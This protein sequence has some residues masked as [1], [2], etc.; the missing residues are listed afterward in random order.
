[1]A[2]YLIKGVANRQL[3]ACVPGM[4]AGLSRAGL[5]AGYRDE[6]TAEECRR[7]DALNRRLSPRIGR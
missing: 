3:S 6:M 2:A 5:F 7:L 4:V 1:M